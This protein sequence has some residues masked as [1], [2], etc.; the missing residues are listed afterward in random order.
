MA[1][2]LPCRRAPASSDIR[3][4]LHSAPAR[5][6]PR[7]P[8]GAWLTAGQQVEPTGPLL[9][10]RAASRAPG[11]GAFWMWRGFLGP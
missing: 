3:R 8:R 1:L 9:S 6:I 7:G 11:T 2:L 10:R 4:D 5:A